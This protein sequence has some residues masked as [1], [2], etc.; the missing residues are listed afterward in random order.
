[1]LVMF[2]WPMRFSPAQE[3]LDMGR[4]FG[5]FNKRCLT[6]ARLPAARNEPALP[7]GKDQ[8]Q[9]SDSRGQ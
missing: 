7:S 9:R 5:R 2:S 8:L 1:M 4:H 3:L 6:K